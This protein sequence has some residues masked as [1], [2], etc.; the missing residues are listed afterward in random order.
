MKPAGMPPD[1]GELGGSEAMPQAILRQG[2]GTVW[3][4]RTE[5]VRGGL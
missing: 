5:V 3:A 1:G 4:A 2:P